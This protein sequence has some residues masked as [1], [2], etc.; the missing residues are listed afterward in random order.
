[1]KTTLDKMLAY[2]ERYETELKENGNKTAIT[3]KEL[4]ELKSKFADAMSVYNKAEKEIKRIANEF[5]DIT[6]YLF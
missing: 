5:D 1:M 3:K 4:Y 6:K 2:I